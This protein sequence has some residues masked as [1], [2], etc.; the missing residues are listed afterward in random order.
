MRAS[1]A[2]TSPAPPPDVPTKRRRPLWP[3]IGFGVFVLGMIILGRFVDLNRHI[4]IAQAWTGALGALA[5]AAYVVVYVVATLL[6]APGTPFTLLCPFL[7]GVVPA[8]AIMI[9]ASILSAVFGF[10]IARYFARD[11]FVE[12]LGGTETYRRLAALVEQH[13]WLVIPILRILPIAPFT[14]VNYGFGLTG[15]TFWRYFFWSSVAMIP[16]DALFV[17]SADLFYDATTYG[18]VAWPLI[19][20]V[21]T[22]ALLVGALLVLGRKTL[23]RL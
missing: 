17:M 4:Q 14:M 5:P 12:R 6:G 22:T 2:T 20:G 8:I 13:D 21:I 19:V 11:A 10:L 1:P 18:Q 23:A 9:V 3:F 16:T 15:I 7:F